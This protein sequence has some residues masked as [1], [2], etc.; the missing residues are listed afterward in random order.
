MSNDLPPD[1]EAV[2]AT[3]SR[4]ELPAIAPDEL[5]SQTAELLPARNAMSLIAPGSTGGTPA[6]ALIP[7]E[8]M[9]WHG[10]PGEMHTM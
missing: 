6:A 4:A 2:V 5:A 8:P 7:D 9:I 1:P 3:P 10:P